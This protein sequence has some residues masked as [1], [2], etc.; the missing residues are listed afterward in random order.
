MKI[1]KIIRNPKFLI[2]VLLTIN[3]LMVKG[4]GADKTTKYRRSSLTMVLV[5]NNDLGR[6]KDMV[7]NAYNAFPFP[8]KYNLHKIVDNKLNT[9]EKQMILSID[10]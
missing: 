3:L 9:T 6:N 2:L 8:D 10:G 7:V 4:Q 5:E 1:I